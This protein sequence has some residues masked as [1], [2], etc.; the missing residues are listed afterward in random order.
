MSECFTQS[1]SGGIVEFNLLSVFAEDVLSTRV[2]TQ[3]VDPQFQGPHHLRSDHLPSLYTRIEEDGVR[4]AQDAIS[5][6]VFSAA[7]SSLDA[8]CIFSH[9]WRQYT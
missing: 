4:A 1:S 3:D 7:H 6:Q 5:I 8:H 9:L 2:R